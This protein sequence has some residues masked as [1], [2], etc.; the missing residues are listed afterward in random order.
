MT[1]IFKLVLA[2]SLGILAGG[3]QAEDSAQLKDYFTIGAVSVQPVFEPPSIESFA[4][5]QDDCMSVQAEASETPLDPLNL[6]IAMGEKVWKLI[7][8]GRPVVNFKTP[9]A[10]ALPAGSNCWY[11]LAGWS[12]PQSTLWSIT[13]TN[14]L[15]ME[16][17]RFNYRVAYAFGGSKGGKGKYLANV[18]VIP[19]EISVKWGFDFNADVQVGRAINLG[20]LEDPR[21]GLQ[22]LV[23]WT[24]KSVLS[25]E[26]RSTNLFVNSN[27]QISQY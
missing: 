18:S 16:I 9:V 13:Y 5:P 17:V 20:T 12:V 27:G 6:V 1:N 2:G 14:L 24:V 11:E 10:H 15:G 23:S 8:A 4:A 25:E 3:A 19:A 26:T 22:L 21:A 7:A